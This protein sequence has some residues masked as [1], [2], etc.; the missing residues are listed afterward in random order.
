MS[1][2]TP[3][4]PS[5]LCMRRQRE[6]HNLP[7]HIAMTTSLL[8]LLALF[9]YLSLLFFISYRSSRTTTNAA[10]FQ[11]E[12]RS[13]WYL[14]AFGMIG[15]SIS[16]VS[17]IS[18]PGWVGNSH[19]TYLQMCLGFIVGYILVA[20]FLLPL[21][22]R[23][24]LT[25]IYT[26]LETRFGRSTRYVGAFYFL[27]SKLLGASARLYLAIFVLHTF[28]GQTF[29]LPFSLTASLSLLIIWLYTRR[30][31]IKTLVRTD[32]LQTLCMLIAL[33]SLFLLLM[34]HLHLDLSSTL[35]TIVQSPLSETFTLHGIHNFPRQF[36]SG[37]F[38]VIVMTGLDQDMMQKNLTCTSLRNAQKDMCTYGIFFLPINLL[39]LSLG[40]LLHLYYTQHA[41][42][43]PS[44]ADSLLPQLISTGALGTWILL[45]FTLGIL[46]AAFS[47][48]DS[49]ITSL[50]TSFCLDILRIDKK[51]Q[52]A[53]QQEAT[54]KRIHLATILLFLLLILLFRTLNTG[55]TLNTIYIMASYTY[56]PLLGLYLFGL[57][58][59]R[60][61]ADRLTPLI[62][63]VSPLL[64]VILDHIAPLYFNYHFGYELLMLNGLLTFLFLFLT[65][66]SKKK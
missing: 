65:S 5:V 33:V 39:F 6:R 21:Y 40:V 62:C 64:C 30:S 26:Y 36:F 50:T 51:Q 54:R 7:F 3:L 16:G 32:V 14:V 38:I 52:S 19:F 9:L 53:H 66:S 1:C 29:S 44:Q 4:Y 63:I 20:F 10:F 24:K 49:A 18:V 35:S 12:R 59:T 60:Q 37:I 28:V 31:G 17:F 46:S 13:P 15:A 57:F 47:S 41:L 25:T 48:A 8:I 43:I 11:A 23:L 56:G 34:Q 27:L 45:P 55:N 61:V 22:Y 42:P 2:N 58:T